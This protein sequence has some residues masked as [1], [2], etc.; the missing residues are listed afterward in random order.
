MVLNAISVI[1]CRSALLVEE[2]GISGENHRSAS[3]HWQILSHNVVSSTPRHERKSQTIFCMIVDILIVLLLW[4]WLPL[5]YLQ[6]LF[7]LRYLKIISTHLCLFVL[8]WLC[9][10]TTHNKTTQKTKDMSHGTHQKKSVYRRRTDNTMAKRKK[11]KR[12]NND[13]QSIHI[14]LKIEQHE[15]H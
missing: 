10:I 1:S 8:N 12:T 11:Y 14:K 9:S 5:W 15:P 13:L 6:T 4:F 2:N 7:T 3:S